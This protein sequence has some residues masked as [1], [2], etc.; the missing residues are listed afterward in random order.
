MNP[1]IIIICLL[2]VAVVAFLVAYSEEKKNV[3]KEVGQ[4]KDLVDDPKILF[5][6][7]SSEHMKDDDIEII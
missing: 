7:S 4:V 5:D 3:R 2:V 1:V 6:D